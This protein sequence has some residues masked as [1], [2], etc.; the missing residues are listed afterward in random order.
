MEYYCKIIDSPVGKLELVAGDNG[1][2]SILWVRNNSPHGELKISRKNDHPILLET[3]K[4]LNEYFKGAHKVFSLQLDFE[5]TDFQKK[6][7]QALLSIPYGQT[8]T[9]VLDGTS[10]PRKG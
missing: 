2:R 3:E 8:R 4:Q 10:T 9:Y 5:G 6:V 7:W 1:V